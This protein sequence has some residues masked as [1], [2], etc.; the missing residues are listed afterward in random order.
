MYLLRHLL[1]YGG[2]FCIEKLEESTKKISVCGA[3]HWSPAKITA[4][5]AIYRVRRKEIEFENG[6]YNRSLLDWL[7]RFYADKRPQ[8]CDTEMYPAD[9][10]PGKVKAR[11]VL[12][13]TDYPVVKSERAHRDSKA[14]T[15]LPTAVAN[16]GIRASGT[17]IDDE[18]D[19][20][21]VDRMEWEGTGKPESI[22]IEGVP[23][24]ISMP[25]APEG[26]AP[27]VEMSMP[28]KMFPAQQQQ[29]RVKSLR[30]QHRRLLINTPSPMLSL[31]QSSYAE[32]PLSN[33]K[34]IDC[35]E[36]TSSALS[37]HVASKL[38]T[39]DGLE[40]VRGDDVV[41][42]PSRTDLVGY[43]SD[44]PATE[45]QQHIPPIRPLA[46]RASGFAGS[47]SGLAGL[48]SYWHA[49]ITVPSGT[50]DQQY[51]AA[52]H[53]SWDDAPATA[54]ISFSSDF[55]DSSGTCFS[56]AGFQGV[57]N[58]TQDE[59]IQNQY[60]ACLT[61]SFGNSTINPTYLTKASDAMG[62][63]PTVYSQGS[64]LL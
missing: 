62:G 63:S 14:R 42:S 18:A 13:S 31:K 33:P 11:N 58:H 48:D 53:P 25:T 4:L 61:P 57:Y 15:S 47:S 34:P 26:C 17:L 24:S 46:P 32:E 5:N 8:D 10:F 30:H 37:F 22:A 3:N 49:P 44:M 12:R 56:D 23:S 29:T 50:G 2:R 45:I 39:S 36:Q 60:T 35:Q 54:N 1:C 40:Y 9:Y 27:Q 21:D 64:L 52:P 51:N 7:A 19:V 20:A 43:P 59:A 28:S 16:A 6:A 41:L 38:W 55:T